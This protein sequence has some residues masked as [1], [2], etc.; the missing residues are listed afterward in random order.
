M[1]YDETEDRLLNAAAHLMIRYGYDKTTLDDVAREAGVSRS[2]LYTRWKKKD[3]LFQALIWR[4]SLRYLEAFIE[5]FEADHNAGTLAGFFHLAMSLLEDNA[6]IAAL[7]KNDS[8]MLGALFLRENVTQLYQWRIQST[9]AFLTVLQQAGMVRA[10]V[11]VHLLS[12]LL[13]CLQF[14]VLK[15]G[16]MLPAGATPPMQTVVQETIQMLN[17]Y[18]ASREVPAETGHAALLGYLHTLYEQ[19]TTFE[20]EALKGE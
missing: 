10:D 13:N 3:A 9:Q 11:D 16:E 12:Y 19:M 20:K 2:T 5:R 1:N 17:G 14:G 4:E 8:H 15:M 18:A 7:Y 6:F